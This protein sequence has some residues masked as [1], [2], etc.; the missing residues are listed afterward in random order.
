MQWPAFI[1]TPFLLSI[2]FARSMSNPGLIIQRYAASDLMLPTPPV[3]QVHRTNEIFPDSLG[4]LGK[5]ERSEVTNSIEDVLS[6]YNN[7]SG[8][9]PYSIAGDGYPA[10]LSSIP[11]RPT[12]TLPSYTRK[13]AFPQSSI[14]RVSHL[15]TR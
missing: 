4:S 7:S 9:L 12:T 14:Q 11:G 15:F 8:K 3:V 13:G 5:F 1:G 10:Y 2:Q 6:G